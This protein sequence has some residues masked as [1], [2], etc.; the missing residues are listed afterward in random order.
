M[1]LRRYVKPLAES[2]LSVLIGMAVGTALVMAAGYDPITFYDA[3]FLKPFKNIHSAMDTLSYMVPLTMTA[4]SF[5]IAARASVFNIGAEGQLYIGALVANAVGLL[6]LPPGV[7][8]A[9]AIIA[10]F[11]AG[12]FWGWVAGILKAKR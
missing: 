8:P 11:L 3:L 10:S 6:S 2:A 9:V 4:L 12:G 5:A 1:T 7:H